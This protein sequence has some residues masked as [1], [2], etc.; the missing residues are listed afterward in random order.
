MVKSFLLSLFAFI[1]SFGFSQQVI[2]AAKQKAS[3]DYENILVKKLSDDENQTS[4]MIWIKE[5]VALHKHVHHTENIFVLKG[6]GEMTIN[7]EKFVIK[8]G[9][10]F[11]IPKNSWHALKVLSSGPVQVISIQSPQFL[12]KDRIFPNG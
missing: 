6:K 4:F 10:Y 7:D 5:G 9:D 12:G 11:S 8:K 1:Y 3:E 2:H